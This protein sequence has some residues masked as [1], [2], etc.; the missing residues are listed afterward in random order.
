MG[1]NSAQREKALRRLPGSYTLAL[2]LRE[3]GMSDEQL[4]LRLDIEIE[5][6]GS[7]LRIAEAKLSAALSQD[8]AKR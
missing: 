2:R 8:D 5:A 4:A 7:F 3:E 6:V 1:A